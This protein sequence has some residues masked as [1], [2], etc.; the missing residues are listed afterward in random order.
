M[1]NLNYKQKVEKYVEELEEKTVLQQA[2]IDQQDILIK[3][4]E[5]QNML[6]KELLYQEGVHV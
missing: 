3:M 2:V 4:L 1:L 6:L 5:E